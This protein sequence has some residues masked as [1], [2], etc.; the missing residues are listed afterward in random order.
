M[1]PSGK[2]AVHTFSNS[3]TPCNRHGVFPAR[4]IIRLITDNAKARA[5]QSLGAATEE[6]LQKPFGELELDAWIIKPVNFGPSKN[7]RS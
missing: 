3:E 2:W 7:I 6:N 5:I 4:Q 1:S